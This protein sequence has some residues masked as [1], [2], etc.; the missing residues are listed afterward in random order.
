MSKDKPGSNV[1]HAARHSGSP[2]ERRSR[3]LAV[4]SR[5]GSIRDC[6][7]TSRSER[8]PNRMTRR[9]PPSGT[10]VDGMAETSGRD[11]WPALFTAAFRQSSNAMALVDDRR[12]HVDVNGPYLNLLGYTRAKLVGRPI[13][14]IVVQRSDRHRG[15]VGSRVARRQLR[16]QRRPRVRGRFDRVGRLGCARRRGHRSPA[17]APRRSQYVAPEP[18]PRRRQHVRRSPALTSRAGDRASSSRSA[19]AARRSPR[20]STSRTRRCAPTSATRWSRRAR[21]RAR[22]WSPRRSPTARS[23]SEITQP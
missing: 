13:F 17:R 6:S 1:A 3:S 14:E 22:T 19:T 8:H 12:R 20:S 23:R 21:G 11:G 2:A 18:A 10:L 4:E 16:G 15:R 5:L 7:A 9:G